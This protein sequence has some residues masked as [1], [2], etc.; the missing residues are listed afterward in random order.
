MIFLSSLWCDSHSFKPT[1]SLYSADVA[2]ALLITCCDFEE[3]CIF[4]ADSFSLVFSLRIEHFISLYVVGIGKK[5]L[6]HTHTHRAKW[7]CE[8]NEEN[9]LMKCKALEQKVVGSS[10][11]SCGGCM[12]LWRDLWDGNVVVVA[13]VG[14]YSVSQS[15]SKVQQASIFE[16]RIL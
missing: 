12:S 11:Y 9:K 15:E 14:L 10:Q 5:K 8:R 4:T 7:K 2:Y 6:P 3:N 13:A 1:V 16:V